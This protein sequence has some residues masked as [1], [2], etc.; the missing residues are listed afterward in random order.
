MASCKNLS[1][2]LI[3]DKIVPFHFSYCYYY[4]YFILKKLKQQQQNSCQQYSIAFS[5]TIRF[6]TQFMVELGYNYVFLCVVEIF[7]IGITFSQSFRTNFVLSLFKNAC[8]QMFRTI[9]E[10]ITKYK[11]ILINVGVL[12]NL[13]LLNNTFLGALQIKRDFMFISLIKKII[14]FKHVIFTKNKKRRY[15]NS[16]VEFYSGG[17][18]EIFFGKRFLEK[19]FFLGSFFSY[20][21]YLLTC[22]IFL[23]HFFRGFFKETLFFGS[24]FSGKSL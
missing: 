4:Y 16:Q 13:I 19:N 24:F 20:L 10:I 7:W 3:D 14:F 1:K 2:Y 21:F 23:G 22:L 6:M 8:K 11:L 17:S 12:S 5:D 15:F 18:K 9:L